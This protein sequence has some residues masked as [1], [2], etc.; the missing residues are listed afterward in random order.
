MSDAGTDQPRCRACGKCCR[1]KVDIEGV[2]FYTDRVCRFWDRET[3]LCTTYDSRH[4]VRPDCAQIER[5]IA[6]GILPGDCPYVRG[7]AG[8]DPPVEYWEDPEVE[9]MIACLPPDPA[10]VF[11]P[12]R[13]QA[14]GRVA[15]IDATELGAVG[16]LRR[17]RSLPVFVAV[18][19]TSLQAYSGSAGASENDTGKPQRCCGLPMAPSI[20]DNLATGGG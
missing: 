14:D 5:A 12:R 8:Y 13:R 20:S 17:S 3:K 11:Y 15:L 18:G 16:R 1:E 19:V 4:E 2:I 6:S 9:A 7:R 10:T